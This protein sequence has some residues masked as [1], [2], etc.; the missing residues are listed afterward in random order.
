MPRKILTFIGLAAGLN[1]ACEVAAIQWAGSLLVSVA[2]DLAAISGLGVAFYGLCGGSIRLVADRLRANYGDLRVMSVLLF[3]A[4]AG[5]VTLSLTPGFVVS[6]GAFAAVGFGL[7]I[8]F[9]C[10][11][12]L[13]AK[14]VP[15][16]KAASMG[17]VAAVGGAPR[18]ILPWVLGVLGLQFSLGAV[19]AACAVVAMS[20]L[21]LIVL[22]FA[23]ANAASIKT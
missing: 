9:P 3:L 10:L 11:F 13:A 7:A 22:T 6:L 23:Q 4:I 19:F 18:I 14:L 20:A 8:T 15:E 12:S 16:A 17:Y 2:P 1:V 5:F 21:A